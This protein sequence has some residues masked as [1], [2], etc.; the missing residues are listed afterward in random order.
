MP[1]VENLEDMWLVTKLQGERKAKQEK[2]KALQE[3]QQLQEAQAGSKV[4]GL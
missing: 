1:V 4:R 2:E 3:M